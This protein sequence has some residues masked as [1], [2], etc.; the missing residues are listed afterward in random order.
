M[1]IGDICSV[2]GVIA[3]IVISI[4]GGGYK[5]LSKIK[6]ENSA[7]AKELKICLQQMETKSESAL[8]D[9]R[10]HM[11]SRID[12]LHEMVEG[13]NSSLQ[14]YVNDGIHELKEDN[15]ELRTKCN[16]LSNTIHTIEKDMLRFK[17][18]IMNDRRQ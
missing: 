10:T 8:S 11:D 15:K 6:A 17:A 1:S 14:Q 7:F 5:L 16:E 13:K 9:L 4:V 3:S 18:D 12:K 2:L